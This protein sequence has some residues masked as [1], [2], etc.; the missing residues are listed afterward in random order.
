PALPE[1][2]RARRRLVGAVALVLAAI[3]GLPMILDSEPKLPAEDIAIQIP[4]RDKPMPANPIAPPTST[5][6]SSPAASIP[7]PVPAHAEQPV[8]EAPIAS[9]GAIAANAKTANSAASA[10]A[11]AVTP[12]VTAAAS[13]APGTEAGKTNDA[14]AEA[15]PDGK[16]DV[17]PGK[18]HAGK[19]PVTFVVQVAAF[20][21]QDKVSELQDKLSNAGIKSYTEKVP[22]VSGPRIRVRIGPFTSKDQADNARVKLSK[23]GLNGTL[24]PS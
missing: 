17:D 10:S 6:S 4:S 5:A 21:S 23:L 18:L 9:A 20:A 13:S 1:K 14:H 24:S 16:S 11:G 2:K 22:T 8:P 7:A 12:T 19:K 3:I 15:A